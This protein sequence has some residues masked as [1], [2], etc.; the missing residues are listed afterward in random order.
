M[1]FD[2]YGATIRERELP[3]VV[4]CLASSVGGLAY[5]GK[6]MPRYGNT[7]AIDLNG[8]M[9]AWVGQDTT[10]GNV[11][12]EAKGDTTPA[13]VKAIRVHFPEHTV[14]RVDVAEDYDEPG[15]FEKLQAIIR[16]A[17]GPKVKGQYIALPDDVEDGRTWTA[18]VRGGV[19]YLRLYEWGK[20]PDRVHLGRPNAVRPELECRPHYARDKAAA[21][22]MTPLEVWGMTSWTQRVGEALTQCPITRWDP[23]VRKYSHDK[24]TRY[25]ALTFRRHLEEMLRNGE[26]IEATFRD[27]WAQKDA[28]NHR[29]RH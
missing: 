21:A 15:V 26:H 8:R 9:A 14:P 29:F 7:L 2:A 22:K 4:D 12:I 5:R 10:S 25:I 20:H 16:T 28:E 19:G 6:P 23:E 24:T 3:Y 13:M 27:V 11:Y 18:G 17:K 1:K